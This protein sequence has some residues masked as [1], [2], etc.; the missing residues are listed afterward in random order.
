VSERARIARLQAIL[1][2]RAPGAPG[3]ASGVRVGIGDDAAVLGEAILGEGGS[4][5]ELVW[6]VDA[7][8]D[9]THFDRRW[10]SWEDVGWRSFMAAASDLAAMG[11]KPIAALGSL[12]LPAGFDD[13]D[14]DAIGRGQAAASR[15]VGAPVVGGNL[16]R[17]PALEI[18]T[19]L[20][21]STR[22]RAALLRDRARA[23]EGIWLAGPVGLAAAGLEALSRT[24]SSAWSGAGDPALDVA[25]AAWR[26]PH[27]R[28]ASGLAAA[29]VASAGIDVSD[30]LACDAAR[31]AEAS[32]VAL[33][34]EEARLLDHGGVA[35]LDA[36]RALGGDAVELA[37]HG[38]E[39]YALLV[40]SR[41]AID[42][43]VRVGTVVDRATAGAARILLANGAS[44]SREVLPRGFD[45]FR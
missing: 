14:L 38:G 21:G 43:F 44:G 39:D 19:T 34:F 4:G 16:A 42:G 7:Q 32:D 41:E 8:V 28:I 13:E 25:I 30:G 26:R 3:A 5:G 27:A 22:A 2:A 37:L 35:L 31:V 18:T 40:T 24:S 15:A 12:V 29:G 10:L 1:E 36:A 11:A 6:T 20:L 23:G 45:H 17:G 9:G 33:V